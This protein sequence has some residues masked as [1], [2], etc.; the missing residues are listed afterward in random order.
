MASVWEIAIK[1]GLGKSGGRAIARRY[2]SALTEY[3]S[4]ATPHLRRPRPPRWPAS[5]PHRDPSDRLLAAQAQIERLT[6]VTAD[7]TLAALGA[8]VLW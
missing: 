7:A 8:P 4:H 1:V 2:R 5:I 3:A 6:L